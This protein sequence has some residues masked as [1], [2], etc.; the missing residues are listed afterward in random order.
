MKLVKDADT[1]LLLSEGTRSCPVTRGIVGLHS[2]APFS[3]YREDA[4]APW[5]TIHLAVTCNQ[6]YSGFARQVSQDTWGLN[7][8]AYLQHAACSHT[9]TRGSRRSDIMYMT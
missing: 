4:R 7:S 3:V 8:L 1:D 6:Y 5:T 9:S 2:K